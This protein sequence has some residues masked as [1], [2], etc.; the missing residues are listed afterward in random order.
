M[1]QF[2]FVGKKQKIKFPHSTELTRIK[3][4]HSCHLNTMRKLSEDLN[5]L[6]W[7][8][9][10]ILETNYNNKNLTL[11]FHWISIF[12]QVARQS[13]KIWSALLKDRTSVRQGHWR[14][15]SLWSTEAYF[16]FAFLIWQQGHAWIIWLWPTSKRRSCH[17]SIGSVRADK[18]AVTFKPG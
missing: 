7:R 2:D 16:L 4:T 9:L 10:R 5:S 14:T 18:I 12:H 17:R 13:I 3:L 15:W 1:R 8:V 11:F 6:L